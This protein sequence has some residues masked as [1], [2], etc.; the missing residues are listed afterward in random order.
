MARNETSR[1][2]ISIDIDKATGKI[3]QF[4]Q[5][6]GN[7]QRKVTQ[8]GQSMTQLAQQTTQAGQ[9]ATTSAVNFQT[10]SQGM[11]N[12]S[13]SAVQTFTSLSNLDRAQ[14]RAKMSVIAVARA[15]DLLNNKIARKN[16]MLKAGTA[17]GEKYTNMLREI[18]TATQDLT[19][20][21]EKQKIEQG[22][23]T[24]IYMLFFA[25]IA[26]VGFSTM[27]TV[28][29]LLGQEKA[30]RI[31]AVLATKLHTV[32]TW[33]NV[34]AARVSS[35]NAKA[36]AVFWGGAASTG[37][38]I[39]TIKTKLLTAAMHGLK[40][41][42]GPVGLAMIGISAAFLAYQ[43]LTEDT[44][45]SVDGF[46][47]GVLDSR[48]AVDGLTDSMDSLNDGTKKLAM[49]DAL[50]YIIAMQD[51]YIRST[52]GATQATVQEIEALDQL[53]SRLPNTQG[54]SKP[55]ALTPEGTDP[56]ETITSGMGS[57]EFLPQAFAQEPLNTAQQVS[58]LKP[59]LDI[60]NR[61]NFTPSDTLYDVGLA[62]RVM[63]QYVYPFGLINKG[64]MTSVTDEVYR[65]SFD[66]SSPT[67]DYLLPSKQPTSTKTLSSL[68]HHQLKADYG[69]SERSD[70]N[71]MAAHFYDTKTKLK[72]KIDVFEKKIQNRDFA[73]H[74]YTEYSTLKQSYLKYF[75]GKTID[76]YTGQ[77]IGTAP[78]IDEWGKELSFKYDSK[79]TATQQNFREAAGYQIPEKKKQEEKI[80][81]FK[82]LYETGGDFGKKMVM[83]MTN[84]KFADRYR[85]FDFGTNV[86][87]GMDIMKDG[88]ID[89]N[90][91]LG[92][93]SM[94]R[95]LSLGAGEMNDGLANYLG[96][97]TER[98]QLHDRK[99]E[100]ALERAKHIKAQQKYGAKEDNYLE[101]I[102]G[103]GGFSSYVTTV[104]SSG[105][106][107]TQH[108]TTAQ[109]NR[110]MASAEAMGRATWNREQ[111][112]NKTVS[113]GGHGG[114]I[115]SRYNNSTTAAD[116]AS[117]AGLAASHDSQVREYGKEAFER[118][119][120]INL[121]WLIHSTQAKAKALNASISARIAAERSLALQLGGQIGISQN[122]ALVIL[123]DQ[124]QGEQT[125]R[126][127]AAFQ[128]RLD[129]MSSG[130][131]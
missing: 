67:P 108:T 128:M 81:Y 109:A 61:S 51:S 16:D 30:A 100:E 46:T 124:A 31:G 63:D 57:W 6:I 87:F 3:L 101:G 92:R 37:L 28:V 129:A 96:L 80:N 4:N 62:Q 15:E 84:S 13:T 120:T 60:I 102:T 35:T 10:M 20:K 27:Q 45:K 122:E 126:D 75:S 71:A 56:L 88:K 86:G 91:K 43:H 93:G 2:T 130:V 118:G 68:E 85:A 119:K 17:S 114:G 7:T 104:D 58:A 76:L 11:L 66:W 59:Q 112:Q 54:F 105:N 12:L 111:N 123:R 21:T 125:L 90:A 113:S 34:R 24:D 103:Q 26:N 36:V 33:D 116:S 44:T 106:L 70:T 99:Y 110:A 18:E 48:A 53:A 79:L 121:T 41:A 78:S 5:T 65:K 115:V 95:G 49:S 19:V 1:L 9:A 127:M 42:L 83:N 50:P 29:A 97:R 47:Q 131:V 55:S 117:F 22:A 73:D 77:V 38:G 64:K 89:D 8:A 23:V 94:I 74:D 14:N 25:N 72:N 107:T 98:E 69:I 52:K 40:F 32:A 39:A 82:T